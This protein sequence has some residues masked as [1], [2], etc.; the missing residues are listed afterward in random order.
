MRPAGRRGE[1]F[2]PPK[3]IVAMSQSGGQPT[4]AEAVR[5]HDAMV[6]VCR[7]VLENNPHERMLSTMN[8]A[9]FFASKKISREEFLVLCG[10][11]YDFYRKILR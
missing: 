1:R 11:T 9:A 5:C 3:L 7:E 10:E 2:L 4:T 6:R 8:A